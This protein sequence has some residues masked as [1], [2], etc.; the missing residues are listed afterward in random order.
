MQELNTNQ[1]G[2]IAELK[3]EIRAIMNGW[4]ASRAPEACR[5][6]YILDDGEKVYRVQVKYSS[7]EDSRHSGGA[8]S[9]NLSS[10]EGNNRDINRTKSKPYN[11]EEID[12]VLVYIEPVD[13]I[14]WLPS[15]K[16]DGKNRIS[17]RYEP[18]ANGQKKGINFLQDYEW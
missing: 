6:D 16:F 17:I 13:K 18:T 10:W 5:Y 2:K 1:K 8:V 12:A 3:V 11:K 4:I 15:D 14:C 7:A 9:V